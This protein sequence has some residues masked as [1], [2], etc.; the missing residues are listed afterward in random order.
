MRKDRNTQP[1]FRTMYL[2]NKICSYRYTILTGLNT[3]KAIAI[4]NIPIEVE[5]LCLRKDF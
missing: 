5:W 2:P 1:E 3:E 4:I